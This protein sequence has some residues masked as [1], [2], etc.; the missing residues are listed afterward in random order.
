MKASPSSLPRGKKRKQ[1]DAY[2]AAKADQVREERMRKVSLLSQDCCALR[3][4]RRGPGK[5]EIFVDISN[6]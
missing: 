1:Q 5:E 3:V 4:Q 2:P 6:T